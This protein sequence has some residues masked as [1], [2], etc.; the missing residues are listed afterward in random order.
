MKYKRDEPNFIKINIREKMFFENPYPDL[1]VYID[2]KISN[3]VDHLHPEEIQLGEEISSEKR[4]CHFLS[5]RQCAQKAISQL[6]MK[7]EPIY[8]NENR[9]PIWPSGIKGSITHDRNLA[10]ALVTKSTDKVQ[11]IG[12]DIEDLKRK[13]SSGISRHILTKEEVVQWN[14]SEDKITLETR[15]IFSI[16]EAIFKC[17]FPLNAIYLG[18]HDAAISTLKDGY[19]K[20][21]LYKHPEITENVRSLP[22]E[23]RYMIKENKVLAAIVYPT[24]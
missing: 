5:G 19:F 12:I 21:E 11:G 14:T 2:D 22:I 3:Q 7:Q 23:G 15:I 16:K 13:L 1:C 4:R 10:A 9:S 8:R 6:K 20:G 17:F 24:K 18:F